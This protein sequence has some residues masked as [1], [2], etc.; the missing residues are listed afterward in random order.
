MEEKARSVYCLTFASMERLIRHIE[1]LLIHNDYVIIPGLGGFVLQEQQAQITP[2]GIVPPHHR[3][4]F[5][6]RMDNND[7]LL[8]T[9]VLRA[10]GITY[11][12]ALALIRDE[13]T[14]A[15]KALQA[16]DDVQLGMLGTLKLNQEKQI[17]YTPADMLPVI[18]G[19]FGLGTLHVVRL[20]SKQAPKAVVIPLPSRRNVFRYAASILVLVAVLLFAPRTGD[21]TLHD[22]AGIDNPLELFEASETVAATQHTVEA[23]PQAMAATSPAKHYHIIVS[24]LANR[25]SAERYCELLQAK[26]YDNAQVLPSLRTNRIAI[27]SFANRDIA[28]FYLDELRANHP[29]FADAWLH[30]E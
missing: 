3:V 13:V 10:E 11:R 26:H 20:R 4:G 30:I 25:T 27:E 14:K 2:E 5:N 15:R 1:N 28:V 8:A 18:P 19:D 17:T 9:E 23:V 6:V 7:G 16:G 12:A 22:V 29:E 21:G 24:C